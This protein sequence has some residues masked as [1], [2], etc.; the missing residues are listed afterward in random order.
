MRSPRLFVALAALGLLAGAPAVAGPTFNVIFHAH[1]DDHGNYANI[2]GYTAPNGVEYALLGCTTGTSIVNLSDPDHPYETGFIPGVGSTW[3]E[4][5]SYGQYCYVVSEGGGGVQIISLANPQSPVLVGAYT[6]GGWSTSHSLHIDEGAGLLYVNGAN[7]GNKGMRILSLAN[8]IAPVEVGSWDVNYVHDCI[9]RN[10]RCYAAS[11][12]DG[13]L[14]VLNVSNPGSIPAPIHTISGYP[15]AFTHNAWLTDN[16]AYVLTTDETTASSTRMWSTTTWAQTDSY[17]PNPSSIPHNVHVDGNLAYLSHYTLGVKILD[18]SNPLDIL[19]IAAYD[20]WAADDG[21]GFDGCWGVFP[22]F[23]TTPGLFVASD[24]TGG[25]YVLEYKGPLGTLA[26]EVR[27]SGSPTVKVAGAVLEIQESGIETTSNATGQYSLVDVAGNVHVEVS[28]FGYDTAVVPATIVTGVVTPLNID[29]VLQPTGSLSGTVRSAIT[30]APIPN[31]EVKILATPLTD[32]TDGVGAYAHDA[33]PVGTYEVRVEAFGFNPM[34]TQVV[35]TAGGALDVDFPLNPAPV[36]DNF[37][38]A[39][40]G[41]II[42]GP[43]SLGQWQRADPQPTTAQ[44]GDDHT[45]PPG[46]LC[47]VTGA[48]AGGSDGANDVDGGETILT[49][50]SFA[51]ANAEDPHLYYWKWYATGVAGNSSVDAFTVRVSSNGGGSWVVI[52]NT[53]QTTNGWQLVDVPLNSYITPTNLVVFQFTARD[54]GAG[55]ITE[56]CIDDFMVYDGPDFL[57][58]SA[59]VIGQSIQHLELSRGFPNPFRAGEVVEADFL[60]PRA[61]DVLAEIHDVSGR[62]VAVLANGRMDAGRHRLLWDGRNT[63]GQPGAA[64][65]YFLRV[66]AQD[67]ERSRKILFLK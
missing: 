31:A 33:I 48:L 24:I 67:E 20:T 46:T 10:G 56:A 57:P 50:P 8:P 54:T 49:S 27:R 66:R 12:Y 4:L 42:S 6:S 65:V 15:G 22:Y 61:G 30:S 41:W 9:A 59:P 23:Q 2:W 28:A 34:E 21:G 11:I 19:E 43:V 38:T 5:K 47:W 39:T 40:A 36:S 16:G 18:I 35:V 52:E 26:G 14:Y 62:R 1:L 32:V 55:S 13:I 63:K 44:P 17:K 51:L 7:I 45:P 37:E 60:L 25:L 58:T 53:T 29:L 3:R 64:G